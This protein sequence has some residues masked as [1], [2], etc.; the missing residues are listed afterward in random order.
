ME[1]SLKPE[2]RRS[3]VP[4][5]VVLVDGAVPTI[6]NDQQSRISTVLESVRETGV[7]YRLLNLL[8]FYVSTV[9]QLAGKDSPLFEALSDCRTNAAGAF[10]NA[11]KKEV[12]SGWG[13][14]GG[15]W[16]CVWKLIAGLRLMTAGLQAG[17]GRGRLSTG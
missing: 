3:R 11:I 12:S 5:L 10:R 8:A 2:R 9:G 7:G 1:R 4:P 14:G 6:A 17:A 13:L 15:E 16:A